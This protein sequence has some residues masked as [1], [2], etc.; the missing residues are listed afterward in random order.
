LAN[1]LLATETRAIITQLHVG[2]A[3]GDTHL[4]NEG[5]KVALRSGDLGGAI[6]DGWRN[7]SDIYGPFN[8]I[9]R[10]EATTFVN[11]YIEST[12]GKDLLDPKTGKIRPFNI[13]AGLEPQVRRT[14]V[15]V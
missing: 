10:K 6:H 14:S 3:I 13:D 4:S 7:A 2:D 11:G 9:T 12:F 5:L 15:D 8:T 1:R